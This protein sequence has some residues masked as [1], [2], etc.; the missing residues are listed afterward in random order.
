MIAHIGCVICGQ[1]TDHNGLPCPERFNFHLR[2]G[3]PNP[4]YHRQIGQNPKKP[5]IRLSRSTDHAI[6]FSI[7]CGY[8]IEALTWRCEGEIDEHQG[9]VCGYGKTPLLAYTQ[10][11]EQEMPF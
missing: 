5:R 11:L 6:S 8:P 9:K 1:Y 2:Q 7:A 4:K 10:W 3:L